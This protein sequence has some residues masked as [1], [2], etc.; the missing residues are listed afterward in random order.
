M[1]SQIN[2]YLMRDINRI[3]QLMGT[4][5][6]HT[7][8]FFEFE[9]INVIEVGS[10]QG[11]LVP[12]ETS[13]ATESLEDDFEPVLLPGGVYAYFFN[14][15]GDHHL[16]GAD[17]ADFS[18]GNGTIDSAFSVG[19]WIAPYNTSAIHT[20]I[21]MMDTAGNNE[22]WALRITA[23]GLLQLELQDAS[24]SA[25]EIALSDKVLHE[26]Q[27]QSV[28]ATYDGT[29]TEP[30][31]SMYRNGVSIRDAAD[32]TESSSYTAMEA[33]SGSLLTVACAGVT[34]TPTEEY[35][36]YMAVPFLTGKEM[37][38]DEV[39]RWHNITERMVMGS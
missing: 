17:S 13:G 28:T 39:L 12:A 21:G 33:N 38:A 6:P 23:A 5:T 15:S 30:V 3:M 35:H 27:W 18:F 14:P 31:I 20:L 11:E 29:E 1:A 8:P 24:A 7:W 4:T 25:T 34:A 22:E 19:M 16:A 26:F 37:T 10:T 9:G 36:G 32:A 2:K